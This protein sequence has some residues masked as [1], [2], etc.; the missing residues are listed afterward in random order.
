MT[1]KNSDVSKKTQATE[2]DRHYVTFSYKVVKD[3]LR[4]LEVTDGQT[5]TTTSWDAIF[6]HV[7]SYDRHMKHKLYEFDL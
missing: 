6:L 5:L 3:Y 2:N 7:Y 4:S 1:Y